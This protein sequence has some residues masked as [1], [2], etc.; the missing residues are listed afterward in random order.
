MRDRESSLLGEGSQY[1]LQSHIYTVAPCS[2][3]VAPG[4]TAFPLERTGHISEDSTVPKDGV[5]PLKSESVAS[6]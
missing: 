5:W 3:T 2:P 4:R 1:L 6:Q